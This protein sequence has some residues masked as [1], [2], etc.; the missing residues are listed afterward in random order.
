LSLRAGLP[1]TR[2]RRC[3]DPDGAPA[4][5]PIHIDGIEVAGRRSFVRGLII[6]LLLASPFWIAVAFAAHMFL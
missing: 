3:H 2:R 6:A 1:L 5:Q 4:E